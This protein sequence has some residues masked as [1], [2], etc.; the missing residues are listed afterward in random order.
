ML[1]LLI[2]LDS[3]IKGAEICINFVSRADDL[4]F[5]HI[6]NAEDVENFGKHF[7]II[8]QVVEQIWEELLNS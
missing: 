4:H 3:S 8:H 2:D 7:Q 6:K 1:F 5:H